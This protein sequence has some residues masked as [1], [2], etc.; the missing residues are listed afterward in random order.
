VGI[1]IAAFGSDNCNGKLP[2]VEEREREREREQKIKAEIGI[3]M[4][5][6]TGKQ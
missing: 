5:R 1:R 4:Y 2:C 6:E 3:D